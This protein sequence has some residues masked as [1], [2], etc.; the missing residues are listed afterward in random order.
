MIAKL[1]QIGYNAICTDLKIVL[2]NGRLVCQ[3]IR[4]KIFKFAQGQEKP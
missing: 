4:M 3:L 1:M 2:K